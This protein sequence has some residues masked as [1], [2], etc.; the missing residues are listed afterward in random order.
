M[1]TLS[2]GQIARVMDACGWGPPGGKGI[3]VY[4]DGTQKVVDEAAKKAAIAWYDVAI[5]VCLQE[6]GGNTNAKNRT[7][8]ARGLWQIMT[9]I[10]GDAIKREQAYWVSELGLKELPTIYHPLVNTGV[11]RRLYNE[12]KW[13]PWEAY[14]TG[15][16]KAHLG[17]GAAAYAAVTD[18]KH[19]KNGIAALVEEIK[20]GQATAEFAGL[21]APG[22][23]LIGGVS[24]LAEDPIGK[25]LTFIKAI[26]ATAGVFLLGLILL[27]LGV[28]FLLSNTGVGKTIKKASPI[29]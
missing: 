18:P 26:A 25:I 10:H 28:W 1:P 29:G 22:G 20:L 5:A 17:K 11:A 21:A 4:D 3:Q 9:S 12:R 6:S 24:E 16:Y 19:N 23:V 15:D 7:S 27:I 13:Q 8:S 14:N 2:P